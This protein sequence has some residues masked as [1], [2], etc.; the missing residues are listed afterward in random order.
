M[1][2]KL[3]TII[4]FLSV[5]FNSL[6]A[7]SD[8]KLEDI[9]KSSAQKYNV[10]A[11]ILKSIAYAETRFQNVIPSGENE[12]GMPHA[13]GIMGLRNDDWFGHSLVVG[14]NLINAPV[15][16][17]KVNVKLNIEAAAALLSKYAN[18][19]NINR[20]D[21]QQWRPVVEKYSGI[22]QDDVK[23]F[24]SFDVFKVLNEG[25]V[26]NNVI[27]NQ[28]Q[29]I[30]MSQFGEEVNPK[31]KLKNIQKINSEQSIQSAEYPPA[32]WDPSNNFTPNSITHLFAVV[33]D[34]EG[35]FAG[36]VSWLKNPAAEAS[37]HYIIRSSDGYIVQLV[38][39]KN[40]A[41]HARCWN[42]I[43]LGVE[44]EGYVNNP[45]YF[46]EA[47]YQS[48][49]AL[50]RHFANT[51]GIP[52]DT[53][54]IIGHYQHTKPWWVSW[55]NNTWNPAHP[56]DAFDP[57]CNTHTDPG[58]YWNWSHY[59]DLIDQGAVTPQV[60]S[61]YPSSVSDTI[62]IYSEIKISF[63]EPMAPV[64]EDA[65][66]ISPDIEGKFTWSDT[67]KILIFTPTDLF[68]Y[69]TKYTVTVSSEA[70]SVFYKKL[71]SDYSFE[72]YTTPDLP[73]NVINVYPPDNSTGISTTAKIT[74]DFNE[75][76]DISTLG[77]NVFFQDSSGNDV[78]YKNAKNEEIN[79]RGVISFSP[80]QPLDY[81]KTYKILLKT[82]I[83]TVGGKFLS[84]EFVS[85]FT[86]ADSL[87]TD[88]DDNNFTS[89][90]SEYSLSQNYPNPFN[91]STNIKFSIPNSELVSLKVYNILGKEV[92]ELIN[93]QKPAGN[94][95]IEFN[96][97]SV[98]GGL[99]SGVY[100]YR[101]KAGNFIST[102]KLILMK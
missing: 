41:W 93:G 85:Y 87:A 90:P 27:I 73:L 101:L 91:P 68:D 38:S 75:P 14:A 81:E 3:L 40:R 94:Y 47:M 76:L 88:I 98:D 69:S 80:A 42:A 53:F 51:Y 19:L 52:I 56:S 21:L 66:S 9:F 45:A 36:S 84:S 48:S 25:T 79:G 55:I 15:D 50:F 24:Y 33:H 6:Y 77:V 13:Y 17:V 96:A 54:R 23:P 43:S 31:N 46:T 57:T 62:S 29:E 35:G 83:K 32:V 63:D 12:N 95:N 10:P 4:L 16:E 67:N 72:F 8:E 20:N 65:F 74:I 86:T 60:V 39:E 26:T 2:Y 1:I 71:E 78:D 18:D 89:I 64:T 7:G 59:F 22:P 44:H 102:K 34:T 70:A 92:A 58:K 97:K 5:S 100:L 49:A 37:S 61:S 11:D 99:T 30:N 28:H 82:G